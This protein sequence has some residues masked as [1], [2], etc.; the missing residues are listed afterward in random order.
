V[1]LHAPTVSRKSRSTYSVAVSSSSRARDGV[2][3]GWISVFVCVGVQSRLEAPPLRDRQVD[4]PQS[5]GGAWRCRVFPCQG[6]AFGWAFGLAFCLVGWDE[7]WMGGCEL[8]VVWE[9]ELTD[10]DW[11]RE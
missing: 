5:L 11:G 3:W 1:K 10:D 6:W 4:A 8:R 2:E 7:A 9:R